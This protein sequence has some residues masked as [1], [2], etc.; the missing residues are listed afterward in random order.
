MT[1]PSAVSTVCSALGDE[2]RWNLLV[3]LGQA[4]ASASALAGEFPISRQA[5][6][7]HLDILRE[8]GLAETEKHGRELRYR[9]LGATLTQLA[10]DLQQIASAWDRRLNTIKQLAEAADE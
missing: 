3:R 6:V 5:I 2:T 7:K 9:A 1:T 4:P 8:A 10:D